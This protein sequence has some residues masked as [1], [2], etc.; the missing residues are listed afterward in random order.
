MTLY[1]QKAFGGFNANNP[2]NIP[3]I[4][5]ELHM[6]LCFVRAICFLGV[7]ALF[8][9]RSAVAQP[10]EDLINVVIGSDYSISYYKSS[11]KSLPPDWRKVWILINRKENA[12]S[13]SDRVQSVRRNMLFNCVRNT[14]STLAS[15][16][17]ADPNAM[18]KPSLQ[19][20]SGFE[21]NDDPI[22]EDSPMA[23]IYDQVCR[24]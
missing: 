2:Y 24:S 1:L 13:S 11:I 10:P 8:G 9:G 14:Y 6:S 18:G 4:L 7:A 22:P 15:V 20:E 16:N 3:F 23:I 17:Y 5:V 19:T 12:S 21:M